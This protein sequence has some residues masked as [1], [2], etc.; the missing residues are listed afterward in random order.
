MT[1][2]LIDITHRLVLDPSGLRPPD[3][4]AAKRDLARSVFF[5]NHVTAPLGELRAE[6][7]HMY[8]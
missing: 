6:Q 7:A 5:H 1:P 3:R 8:R 2:K 4:N